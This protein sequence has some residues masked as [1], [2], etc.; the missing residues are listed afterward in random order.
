MS[1]RF[2][3]GLSVVLNHSPVRCHKICFTK[4]SRPNTAVLFGTPRTRHLHNR[5]T[6]TSRSQ[7]FAAVPPHKAPSRR[8]YHQP[9]ITLA[10][11]TFVSVVAGLA[12]APG[13][14]QASVGKIHSTP[15]SSSSSSSTHRYTSNQLRISRR[16]RRY[17][18]LPLVSI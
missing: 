3:F 14:G 6:S 12:P 15:S 10:S 4:G 16:P 18:V 8:H 9:T 17:R 11:S 1:V 2:I 13:S 7:L 5:P